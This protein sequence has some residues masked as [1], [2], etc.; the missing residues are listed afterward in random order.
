MHG[1]LLS[2]L[3]FS[4]CLLRVDWGCDHRLYSRPLLI[5]VFNFRRD[6]PIHLSGFSI[7]RSAL[8]FLFREMV[9]FL[10]V[11]WGSVGRSRFYRSAFAIDYFGR[12]LHNSRNTDY[13][14]YVYLRIA[15]N[16]VYFSGPDILACYLRDS[17]LAN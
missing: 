10:T 4:F 5:F 11:D 13:S 7:F 6:S 9:V 15:R 12:K 2:V 17:G 1:G 8:Y 3:H 14:C 16:I